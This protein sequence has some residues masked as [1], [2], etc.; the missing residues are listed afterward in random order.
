MKIIINKIQ[1]GKR[2]LEIRD[3]MKL[4]LEDF[5]KIFNA[6]KSNVSKWERGLSLPNRA[7]LEKIAKLGDISVNELLY[8]SVEE[9]V[10]TN[11]ADEKFMFYNSN[12]YTKEQQD[13]I[14]NYFVN[15]K[16]LSINDID[17]LY[18]HMLEKLDYFTPVTTQEQLD[19]WNETISNS[20][21]YLELYEKNL[22]VYGNKKMAILNALEILKTPDID[23][24]FDFIIEIIKTYAQ[25]AKNEN[26]F[27]DYPYFEREIY[28]LT[29]QYES[30][31]K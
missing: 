19:K 9:F 17:K 26:D 11:L 6:E 3:N 16:E 23:K 25:Q 31:D 10:R 7:R 24:T 28:E 29:T 20:D 12:L 14:I 13:F 4:N 21:L 5:G 27:V 8:G 1:V 15:N 30:K 22:K 2:I 18:S